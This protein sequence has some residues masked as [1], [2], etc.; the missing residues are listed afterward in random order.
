MAVAHTLVKRPNRQKMRR[1]EGLVSKLKGFASL[2]GIKL[3]FI[4]ED[5]VLNEL[6]SHFSRN[7]SREDA[8]R[9]VDRVGPMPL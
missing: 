2:Q 3:V 8:Q 6:Y 5:E 9:L 4:A 7:M 1:L